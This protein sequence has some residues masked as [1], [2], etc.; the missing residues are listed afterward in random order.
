MLETS[1]HEI[2]SY[3][4]R[5]KDFREEKS[6]GFLCPGDLAPGPSSSC[7]GKCP[8]GV[9]LRADFAGDLKPGPQ[10]HRIQL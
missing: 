5:R 1:I 10:P 9:K 4:E 6:K 8:G 2:V 3:R 7:S